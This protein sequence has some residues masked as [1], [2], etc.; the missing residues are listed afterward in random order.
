M[1]VY[2]ATCKK[3]KKFYIGNT[4][5]KLKKRLD[6]HVGDVYD[7]ANKKMTSDSFA[8]HFAGNF[9][10]DEKITRKTVR[11]C[12]TVDILWKVNPI[13]CKKNF[14]HPS[15]ALCMKERFFIHQAI[16]KEPDKLINSCNKLYGA[17]RH[18]TKFH[19]YT[20]SADQH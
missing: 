1:V 3:S 18:K 13:S 14:G 10:E 6:Q 19:W 15:C 4:Q 5:Q 12:I 8:R 11:T 20:S 9:K 16:R 2:K 17:C 7:L